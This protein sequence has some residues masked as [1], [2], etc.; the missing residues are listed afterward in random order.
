LLHARFEI[1]HDSGLTLQ[2]IEHCWQLLW[3]KVVWYTRVIQ[4]LVAQGLY[5]P[6]D[7]YK[8]DSFVIIYLLVLQQTMDWYVRLWNLHWV[9]QINEQGQYCAS[10]VPTQYFQ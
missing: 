9:W 3:D 5:I 4:E 10:H 6:D 7:V 8:R 1:I 2:R